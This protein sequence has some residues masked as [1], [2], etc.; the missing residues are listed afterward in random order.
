MVLAVVVKLFYVKH[1]YII[2]FGKEKKLSMAWTGV[3]SIL[4]PKGMTSHKSFN[5]PL[6]LENTDNIFLKN[7]H[8]KKN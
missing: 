5:L 2:I 3:A 8:D 6:D 1:Y 4:L 7:K